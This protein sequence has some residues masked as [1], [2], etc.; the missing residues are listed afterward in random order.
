MPG[1]H[2]G[3][4]LCLLTQP[5]DVFRLYETVHTVHTEVL[6]HIAAGVQPFCYA[7][8]MI[9]RNPKFSHG[10]WKGYLVGAVGDIAASEDDAL[11]PNRVS[12]SLLFSYTVHRPLDNSSHILVNDQG[13]HVISSNKL[14]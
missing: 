1:Q 9:F 5:C 10:P 6:E 3:V 8:G 12:N 14:P 11:W 13:S 4:S 2:R 7:E